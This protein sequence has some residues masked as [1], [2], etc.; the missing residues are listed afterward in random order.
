LASLHSFNQGW[1]SSEQQQQLLLL[2]ACHLAA[3][4]SLTCDTQC[5]FMATTWPIAVLIIPEDVPIAGRPQYTCNSNVGAYN[6]TCV[7]AR[8]VS[9]SCEVEVQCV[10]VL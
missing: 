8:E 2:Q 5:I 9:S 4:S 6:E 7:G 10:T 1:L 3:I